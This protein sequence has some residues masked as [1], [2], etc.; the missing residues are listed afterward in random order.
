MIAK[1]HCIRTHGVPNF[2]DPTFGPNGHGVKWIATAGFEPQVPAFLTAAKACARVGA[3][4][5]GVP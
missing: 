1:A 3:N 4:V 2:S 5:P